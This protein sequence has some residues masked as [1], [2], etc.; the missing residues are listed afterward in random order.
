MHNLAPR[1]STASKEKI[2]DGKEEI[3]EFYLLP[4]LQKVVSLP[5]NARILICMVPFPNHIFAAINGE[6][7]RGSCYGSR[8]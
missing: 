5:P 7:C 2:S 8:R 6:T 4:E 1:G 3:L